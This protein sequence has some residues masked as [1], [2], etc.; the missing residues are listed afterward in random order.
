MTTPEIQ[1]DPKKTHAL[2]VGIETYSFKVN[3]DSW[4][5]DGPANDAQ[6]KIYVNLGKP[7]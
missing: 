2:I 6:Q 1:P 7:M 3:Q 5:L 4:N